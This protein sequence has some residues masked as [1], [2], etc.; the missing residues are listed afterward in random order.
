MAHVTLLESH[1]LL[2]LPVHL[3]SPT[4]LPC[5]KN[6]QNGVLNGKGLPEG[7]C[8]RWKK[9]GKVVGNSKMNYDQYPGVL[10][11]CGNG[12]KENDDGDKKKYDKRESEEGELLS[13]NSTRQGSHVKTEVRHVKMQHVNGDLEVGVVEEGDLGTYVCEVI[14]STI[15]H[16]VRFVKLIKSQSH[17]KL[18]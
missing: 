10:R 5:F 14:S 15:K 12:G 4:I 7:Y 16:D 1:D 17:F 3:H 9:G 13:Y 8:V 2:E 18:Q 6:Q 11:A